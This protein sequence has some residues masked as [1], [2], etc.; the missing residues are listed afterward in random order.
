L[1]QARVRGMF[2]GTIWLPFAPRLRC[3]RSEAS[4]GRKIQPAAKVLPYLVD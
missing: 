4:F 3:G 1:P 2:F